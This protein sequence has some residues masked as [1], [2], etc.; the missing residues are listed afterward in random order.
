MLPNYISPKY[1]IQDYSNFSKFTGIIDCLYSLVHKNYTHA[2]NLIQIT[3]HCQY[4]T[5]LYCSNCI[6]TIPLSN[7]K[8]QKT[9][10]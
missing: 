8:T 3:Q 5:Y 10:I 4:N 7:K 6:S 1:K 9:Q 2:V